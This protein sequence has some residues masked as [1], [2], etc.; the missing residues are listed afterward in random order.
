MNAEFSTVMINYIKS[1]SFIILL[2]FGYMATAIATTFS[3]IYL[4]LKLS[5]F[6]PLADQTPTF[7]TSFIVGATLYVIYAKRYNHS[8]QSI[9]IRNRK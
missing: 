9:L 4:P 7:V 5:G 2:I 3:T 6:I 8:T 1:K